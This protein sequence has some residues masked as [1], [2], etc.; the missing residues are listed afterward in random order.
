MKD[1]V[2]RLVEAMFVTVIGHV[3]TAIVN[4]LIQ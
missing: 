3:F 2:S 4:G 1:M